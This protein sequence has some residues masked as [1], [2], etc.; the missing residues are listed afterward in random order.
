M[1]PD[2]EAYIEDFLKEQGHSARSAEIHPL[3]GDGSKR[4]FWRI[5]LFEPTTSFIAMANPPDDKATHR[6]NFAYVMIGKHLHDRGIPVPRIYRYNLERGWVIME[7]LGRTSLQDLVRSSEDPL[8]VYEQVIEHLLRL[9]VEGRK[10]FD[11]S[12]CS[13]TKYYDRTVMKS[14]E[15]DYFRDAFL[16]RYL[17]LKRD[18]PELECAFDHLVDMASKAGDRFFLHRDFQSRNVLVS[19]T[20]IGFVD[21]QGGRL[22]P[23]GYDL[24]S[25]L[26]DPYAAISPPLRERIFAAYLDL[27]SQHEPTQVGPLRRSYPYLAILRNL[28]ILGA[29]SYLSRVMKKEGF[30]IYIPTALGSL[31]ELLLGL[32]DPLLTPLKDLVA[33]LCHQKR[34]DTIKVPE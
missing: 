34:L 12:W 3:Q 30:E 28:Q 23:L 26:I 7:D 16:S 13:Q 11:L 21:W 1:D 10:G 20:R 22:G 31:H 29:F 8:P 2:L 15:T 19:G 14:Y 4:L 32:P 9:Q 17:G 18:W 25:L 5:A 33:K 27:L 24:A 6:E